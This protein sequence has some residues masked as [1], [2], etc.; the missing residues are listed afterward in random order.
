VKTP[1][2]SQSSQGLNGLAMGAGVRD[3]RHPAPDQGCLGF[4]CTSKACRAKCC[5]RA[6]W[7]NP[8][9]YDAKATQLADMFAD[10]F[11]KYEDQMS[12]DVR[13]AGLRKVKAG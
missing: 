11:E 1:C 6:T 5:V 10:N 12:E 4:R 7:K 13:S 2:S 3:A 9:D 8:A